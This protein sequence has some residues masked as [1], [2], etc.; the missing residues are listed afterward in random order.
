MLIITAKINCLVLFCFVFKFKWKAFWFVYY[1]CH[2]F[3]CK[4]SI[5]LDTNQLPEYLLCDLS[6]MMSSKM[7]I[8]LARVEGKGDCR[9]YRL[10]YDGRSLISS[11]RIHEIFWLLPSCYEI[12]FRVFYQTL[13][14]HRSWLVS[15]RILKSYLLR[16]YYPRWSPTKDWKKN[17]FFYIEVP[18]KL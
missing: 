3:T 5:L 15:K 14:S 16:V 10:V 6:E 8:S 9:K 2:W 11:W 1:G 18:L 17:Q 12:Y 4:Q 13:G 7:K